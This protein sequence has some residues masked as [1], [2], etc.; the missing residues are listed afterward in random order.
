MKII[1]G[2]GN[3][4][5]KYA[6]TRHNA[7]FMMVE[8]IKES[9]DF[10]DF[11]FNKK[12]NC[13]ISKGAIDEKE[14]LLAKPQTFMNNSGDSVRTLVDFYKLTPDDIIV[15]HDDIDLPLGRYKIAN[16]SGSAGHNGVEDIISKI[17]TKDFSRIR[18]GIAN[19]S[20]RTEI[21]PADFVLQ[22]FSQEELKTITGEINENILLEIKKYSN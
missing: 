20:L 9:Y 21:E 11:K 16:S 3:P 5:K 15:I 7:G 18:I 6:D 1:I 17:G 13:E 14:I 22:K 4:G 8:K 2:L 19:E 12:L 10:P